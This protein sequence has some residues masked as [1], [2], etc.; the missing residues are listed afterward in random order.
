MRAVALLLLLAAC[1]SQRAE[2]SGSG[3][4]LEAAAIARGVVRDP[5]ATSA[6]GLYAREG[7]R[8]CLIER[9]DTTRI[10]AFIDY[11]DGIGCTGHG[12]AIRDGDRLRVDF[13]RGCRFV[14]GFDGDHV[15]FPGALPAACERLC[16]RRASLAG[17]ALDRL[18][19]SASE[20]EALRDPK[21]RAL[22]G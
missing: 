12:G 16:T 6:T 14:A 17:L 21:G 2:D 10:G 8:L 22:C 13:G 9:G 7:D 15:R 11:G 5:A 20:A 18:S 1:S 3:T 4:A 19:G